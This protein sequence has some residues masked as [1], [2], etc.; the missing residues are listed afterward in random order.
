[1]QFIALYLKA[2]ESAIM[3]FDSTRRNL[4]DKE[5]KQLGIIRSDYYQYIPSAYNSLYGRIFLNTLKMPVVL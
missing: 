2:L 1:M 3:T 5:N 4:P